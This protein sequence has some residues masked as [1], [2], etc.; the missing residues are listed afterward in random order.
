MGA[1]VNLKNGDRSKS[2]LQNTHLWSAKTE[3]ISETTVLPGV[4]LSSSQKHAMSVERYKNQ[5][6]LPS[7]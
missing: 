7:K 3:E 5:R 2:V 6:K 1:L 4:E